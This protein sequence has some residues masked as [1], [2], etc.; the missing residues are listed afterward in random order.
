MTC[1]LSSEYVCWGGL[2]VWVGFR[3]CP[4][5]TPQEKLDIPCRLVAPSTVCAVRPYS[6]MP[7]LMKAREM[8]ESKVVV[9]G[10]RLFS[11]DGSNKLPSKDR[12]TREPGSNNSKT[13]IL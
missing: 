6:I 10:R 7:M 9:K 2:D 3:A 11:R 5:R 1:L 4:V 12:I 8:L 13:S